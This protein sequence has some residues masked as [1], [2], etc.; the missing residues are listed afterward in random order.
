M[1]TRQELLREA[2]ILKQKLARVE[3]QINLTEVKRMQKIAGILKEDRTPDA[4]SMTIF[5]DELGVNTKDPIFSSVINSG[6]VE[7]ALDLIDDI[8]DLERSYSQSDIITAMQAA[9]F[10]QEM[11]DRII[12]EHPVVSRLERG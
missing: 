8:K 11:I 9:Q 4:I 12:D 3:K 1:K 5:L 10:S 7:E 6:N 2:S